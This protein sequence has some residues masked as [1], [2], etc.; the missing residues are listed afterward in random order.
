MVFLDNDTRLFL[1]VPDLI[2]NRNFF[3]E[4]K[5]RLKARFQQHEI[6]ITS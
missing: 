4:L 2:E 1:D 3:V 5:E 6:S